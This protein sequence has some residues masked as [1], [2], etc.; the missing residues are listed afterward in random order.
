MGMHRILPCLVGTPRMLSCLARMH[1]MLSCLMSIQ[2]T[3]MSCE[4]W[5]EFS[6]CSCVN[7][8]QWCAPRCD[9]L[10]GTFVLDVLFL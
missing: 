8:Q 7:R 1:G 6:V 10:S 9:F 3:F 2:T 4:N 5:T